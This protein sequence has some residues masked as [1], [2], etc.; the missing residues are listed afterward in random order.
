MHAR[1][2]GT[3]RVD[4]EVS[5]SGAVCSAVDLVEGAAL[6]G[7]APVGVHDEVDVVVQVLDGFGDE[8]ERLDNV[9][10]HELVPLPVD[11]DDH[12]DH[13]VED[14]DEDLV[15]ASGSVGALH[16]QV[17]ELPGELALSLVHHLNAGCF[18]RYEIK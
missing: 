6:V 2:V 15:V 7:S 3:A 18:E 8:P 14:V 9:R 17:E 4:A 16:H 11:E 12:D 5:L 13:D 10:D 1:F